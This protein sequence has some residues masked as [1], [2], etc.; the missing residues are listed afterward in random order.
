MDLIHNILTHIQ[1]T[2]NRFPAEIRTQAAETFRTLGFPTK[3]QE[4]WKY[5]SLVALLDNDF[6]FTPEA[7]NLDKKQA[8]P[9]FLTEND[10]FKMVFVNGQLDS[11]LSDFSSD[12]FDADTL[13]N[14]FAKPEYA[15][16]V[17]DYFNKNADKND[18]FTELNTATATHGTFVRIKKNKVVEK[19]I[20][21]VYLTTNQSFPLF[22]NVRNLIIA[23]ENTDAK[24]VEIHRSFSENI[25]LTNSV[26]EI[27]CGKSAFLDYYKLQNDHEKASLID[28]TFASQ[29]EK[30]HA[31]VHTFSFGGSLTRNNLNFYQKGEYLEST[32]KGVTILKDKQHV[33][34]YTLVNHAEPN[35]ES[36]QDYKCIVDDRSTNVFNGKI[37]VEKIAQ[38]TN[39]YQQNDN[40]LLSDK[41]N[42][43]TKPQLEIFADDVKC[44]HGC[45][46]GELDADAL[47]Y[48]QTRGIPK[49]EGQALL[50]YAFANTV[51]ESVKISELSE[52]VNQL[53][54]EKLGVNVDF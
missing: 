50:M 4:A 53:I 54:S 13:E 42:I 31:S 34:H 2:E 29:E 32:L 45:T 48:L 14:L 1:S 24:I 9:Y 44:S 3:K 33:D 19:P 12:I 28:N 35:C 20:Q 40:I 21:I 10:T 43:Y 41:A 38:K 18:A 26:T 22:A 6:R 52:K 7:S 8:E 15:T 5:T 51:L 23:E 16:I 30:S 46:I 25:V 27:F 49:K 39:A 37:M 36:H 17:S 47:F 11:Q